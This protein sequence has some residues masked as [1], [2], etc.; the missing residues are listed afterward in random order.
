MNGILNETVRQFLNNLWN[1]W[2]ILIVGIYLFIRHYVA[3]RRLFIRCSYKVVVYEYHLG[4]R[5][6]IWHGEWM[7]YNEARAGGQA[8]VRYLN[9]T[10]NN[11]NFTYEVVEIDE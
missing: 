2:I 9:L 4:T 11:N 7:T 10:T 8:I 1:P 3:I 5:K 6:E